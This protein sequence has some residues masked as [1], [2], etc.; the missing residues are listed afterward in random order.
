MG[1]KAH[2]L[3]DTL[4]DLNAAISKHVSLAKRDGVI[5]EHERHLHDLLRTIT[6]AVTHHVTIDQLT[7]MLQKGVDVS[8]YLNRTAHAVGLH[9]ET[10]ETPGTV[11]P[12][13][14]GSNG[15]ARHG[16]P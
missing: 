11:T 13:P 10:H 5:D 6:Q 3:E 7:A 15:N 14:T 12:F 1:N 16:Q 4:F 8:P 9:I 2:A